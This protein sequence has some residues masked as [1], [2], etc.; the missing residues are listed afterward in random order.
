MHDDLIP[1]SCYSFKLDTSESCPAHTD[2]F[3]FPVLSRPLKY[4]Y[5]IHIYHFILFMLFYTI[6]YYF[7]LFYIILYFYFS[8]LAIHVPFKSNDACTLLFVCVGGD[9]CADRADDSAGQTPASFAQRRGQHSG[10]PQDVR[11]CHHVSESQA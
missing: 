2:A 6:L 3:E 5:N 4:Q 8:H 9:G 7:I 1:T 10:S 11:R